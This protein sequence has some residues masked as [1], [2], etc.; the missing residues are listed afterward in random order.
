MLEREDRLTRSSSLG[1]IQ[2]SASRGLAWPS[3]HVTWDRLEW[4]GDENVAS[5]GSACSDASGREDESREE[6]GDG[7]NVHGDGDGDGEV[8][9][10]AVAP[11]DRL[12]E[13]QRH[14]Q[15]ESDALAARQEHRGRELLHRRLF[16]MG[17]ANDWATALRLKTRY[18]VHRRDDGSLCC[19]MYEGD[20][21][22]Q[23]LSL[24]LFERR[25]KVLRA[26]FHHA[27]F[28]GVCHTSPGSSP[29]A[30]LTGEQG[31]PWLSDE[32]QTRRG[33]EVCAAAAEVRKLASALRMQT[34]VLQSIQ[35][36]L[37]PFAVVG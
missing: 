36:S 6:L 31:Q 11:K 30:A 27:S 16:L 19:H 18:H 1:C 5:E 3:R 23:E 24:K 32:Q 37:M 28:R 9:R 21:F 2:G 26:Q 20:T 14:R 4:G 29:N 12:R 8:P 22:V 15:A 33:A 34:E 25:H 13:Y 10:A 7:A 17:E 35:P